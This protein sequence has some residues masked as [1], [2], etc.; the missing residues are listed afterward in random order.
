[1]SS[2]EFRKQLAREVLDS[3]AGIPPEALS[4]SGTALRLTDGPLSG[5]RI[6]F[7]TPGST[8]ARRRA[9]LIAV[10]VMARTL[11]R[12]SRF[13]AA[14]CLIALTDR[15]RAVGRRSRRCRRAPRRRRRPVFSGSTL[16]PP[17]SLPRAREFGE[18]TPRRRLE[19]SENSRTERRQ[20]RGDAARGDG[21]G[22]PRSGGDGSRDGDS[23]DPATR[24]RARADEAEANGRRALELVNATTRA[25]RAARGDSSRVGR[26][27]SRRAGVGG[28]VRH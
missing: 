8:S 26:F 27:D 24:E 19:V 13:D 11:D 28:V 14:R 22:H 17:Q 16:D 21:D 9:E 1:M 4:C 3:L 10:L 6:R 18:I 25:T 23:D 5:S 20:A 15:G 12:A 7:T 2:N